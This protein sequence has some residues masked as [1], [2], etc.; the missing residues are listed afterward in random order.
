MLFRKIVQSH[1]SGKIVFPYFPNPL[2]W[3][4]YGHHLR[5]MS[6]A[7]FACKNEHKKYFIKLMIEPY[8]NE[9]SILILND[10]FL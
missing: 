10:D 9:K 1:N 7:L 8:M 3:L 6:L 2:V 5:A 4:V